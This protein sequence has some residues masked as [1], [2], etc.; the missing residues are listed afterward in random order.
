MRG[1]LDS[2][3]VFLIYN[4]VIYTLLACAKQASHTHTHTR[5]HACTHARTHT[6]T[7]TYARTHTV[8]HTHTHTPCGGRLSGECIVTGML[9]NKIIDG[10]TVQMYETLC[11]RSLHGT[12]RK[13]RLPVWLQPARAATPFRLA[14][15]WQALQCSVSD[16]QENSA[17]I[18]SEAMI[19]EQGECSQ[20][21]LS[22][23][24]WTPN[25][26]SPNTSNFRRILP[27]LIRRMF[28]REPSWK[29]SAKL[30]GS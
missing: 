10:M 13:F 25:I 18:Q 19:V 26:A 3:R 24:F 16:P 23:A 12:D 5:T 29:Y 27:F 22:E 6:F 20:N 8:T 2:D 1:R 28:L 17:L 30:V 7:H 9:K 4:L 14:V 11:S 15:S 21:M